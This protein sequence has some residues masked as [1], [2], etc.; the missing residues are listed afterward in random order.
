MT[1]KI[2]VLDAIMG[3]GKSTSVLKWV[4]EQPNG[5]FLYVTP[6]LSESEVRV[7]EACTVNKFTAP[8]VVKGETK[9]TVLL[10]MLKTGVNI[11]IT[12]SLYSMLTK[13]HLSLLQLNDY[14][15]ILD[16]EVSFIYPIG[17]DYSHNDFKYLKDTGRIGVTEDGR[18]EWLDSDILENTKYSKLANMCNLSMVYEAKRDG[19]WFVCQIPLDLLRCAKRV[20]LMTYLFEGSVLDSF[21]KLKGFDVTEFKEV[22]V[23]EVSKDKIRSLITFVGDRQVKAWSAESFSS[24]WYLNKANQATLT[25]LSK[26]IRAIANSEKVKS[27][28]MLWCVPSAYVKPKRGANKKVAPS[29]YAAGDGV[30]VGGVAQGNFLQ[31]S[32]RA[33][34]AYRDRELMIHCFNRFPN[35]A[36][37]VYLEDYGFPVDDE[38]F[39]LSEFLQWLWRSRIRDGLPIK[40]CILPKRM[41][42][43][44]Q[45]WLELD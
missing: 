19:G 5:C 45:D 31:C 34:N 29:S 11:S 4:D 42:K 43:L 17:N 15:I 20:I 37:A 26:D 44:F 3:S 32:S 9:S 1:N 39:A 16:E 38:Q 12:Q 36:V 24:H 35:R 33:T 22:S 23:R 21:L 25:K 18:V 41:R 8:E 13:E 2:E 14:T 40:V 27:G 30:I 10:D 28:D 6:L 7:V